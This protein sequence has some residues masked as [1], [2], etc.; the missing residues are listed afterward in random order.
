L[1][2]ACLVAGALWLA[3]RL[4]STAAIQDCVSTGRRDCGS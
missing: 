4:S 2:L 1:L 3:H